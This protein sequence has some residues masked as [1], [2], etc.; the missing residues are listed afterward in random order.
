MI[1]TIEVQKRDIT[2][3]WKLRKLRAQGLVPA[4][5][6]G[7]GEANV[8]LS[9]KKETVLSLVR[10]G[11]KLVSLTGA[12]TDTALLR[13][14]QWD[15]LGSEIVH[16]DFA[17]VSQ[18]ETVEISLPIHLHGEAPGAVGS[19]QLRFVTHEV[20]ISCPA[21]ALPEFLSVD[22][23]KLMMGDSIHVNEMQLP[24]GATAVTPGAVV[25]VQVVEQV[26]IEE[27]VAAVPEP[28]VIAKGKVDAEA[29]P[30]A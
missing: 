2:G 1:E 22:I 8:C 19:G 6:Y 15:S 5:L 3:S 13:E 23:S 24:A 30:K 4:I 26:I 16:L 28:E 7:H 29:K 10:H 14:V 25:I 9:L 27:P 18:S 20:T 21:N 11:V 12:I 17:R